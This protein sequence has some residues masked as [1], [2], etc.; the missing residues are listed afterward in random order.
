MDESFRV[1]ELRGPNYNCT[2]HFHPEY[3]LGLV[4]SGSGHRIV[5]DNISPLQPGDFALLGPNLPHAWQFEKSNAPG[6]KEIHSII[7]YFR[8]DSLGSEFFSRPEAAMVQRLLKR[9]VV[10]IAAKGRARRECAAQIQ[11]MVGH[12]GMQRVIDLLQILQ[13]LATSEEIVPICSAGFVPDLPDAEGER[14][15]KICALIQERIAEPLHRDDIAAAAH[16]SPAAFSRFF[17]ARTGKTF[18]DFVTELRIS[19]ACRLLAERELHVTEVAFASGFES[20]AGFN[21]CF[22][23]AKS[24]NPTEYRRRL[25]SLN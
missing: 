20:V 14:L 13:R 1:S 17:K 19:R 2:W 11:A 16:F 5:G 12:T 9:S 8:E 18:H 22:R 15:R 23:R 4:L 7:V 21:R 6:A 3:Q 10:G 24:T 25:L